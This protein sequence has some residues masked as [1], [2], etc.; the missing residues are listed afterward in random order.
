FPPGQSPKAEILFTTPG[1]AATLGVPLVKGRDIAWTD[2]ARS[3]R[4]VLVNE[5]LVRKLIPQGDPI[6]RRILN[7]VGESDWPWTIAGVVGAVRTAGLDRAPS[8][9]IIVPMLQFPLSSVRLAARS[10]SGSP[11]ALLAP[12]RAEIAAIDRDLPLTAPRT[13]AEVVNDSVAAQ[14]FQ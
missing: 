13:L 8:P 5:A 4:I 11:F 14:R 6:G 10:A 2:T 9:L 7:L 1:W 3:A 12:I